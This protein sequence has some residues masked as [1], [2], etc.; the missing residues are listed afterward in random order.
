MIIA[1][2]PASSAPEEERTPSRAL[3]RTLRAAGLVIALLATVLTAALGLFLTPVRLGGVP[4]GASMPAKRSS[5]HP[6]GPV[7]G[8]RAPR[9]SV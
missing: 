1:D 5:S 4:V 6:C 3:D 2:L 7:P 9:A 8:P